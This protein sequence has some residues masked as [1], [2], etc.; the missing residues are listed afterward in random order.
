[1]NS[2]L[3]EWFIIWKR[4]RFKW[5]KERHRAQSLRGVQMQS[6]WSFSPTETCNMLIL[7][8]HHVWWYHTQGSTLIN[9]WYPEF[10]WRLNYTLSRLLAVSLQPLPDVRLRCLVSSFFRGWSSEYELILSSVQLLIC[11]RLFMTPWT[12]THQTHVLR[13]SDNIQPSHPLWPLLFLPSVFPSHQC[14][15]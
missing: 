3:T 6:F 15:S 12:A 9:I 2:L 5:P 11:V 8:G 10:L 13:V 4:Y 14:L 7:P 1:M